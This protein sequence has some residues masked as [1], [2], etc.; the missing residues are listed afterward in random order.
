MTRRLPYYLALFALLL[1]HPAQAQTAFSAAAPTTAIIQV[2]AGVAP[3]LVD[4]E[5]TLPVGPNALTYECCANGSNCLTSCTPCAEA[6]SVVTTHNATLGCVCASAAMTICAV[7]T[8]SG[9]T[10]TTQSTP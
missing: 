1:P 6:S 2:G 7:L 10:G 4:G 3:T 8:G 5:L 9:A